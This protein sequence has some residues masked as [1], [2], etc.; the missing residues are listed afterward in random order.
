MSNS[1]FLLWLQFFICSIFIFIAGTRLSLNADIIAEKMGLSKSWIGIL[2]LAPITSGP[3]AFN[4]LSAVLWVKAPDIA[5]GGIL[6]SCVCNLF[7]LALLGLTIG[8]GLS[9]VQIKNNHFLSISFGILMLAVAGVNILLGQHLAFGWISGGSLILFFLYPL[10]MFFIYKAE[11]LIEQKELNEN[12]RD[13]S[14]SHAFKNFALNAFIILIAATWLPKVGNDLAV[15]TSLGQTFVGSIFIAISTSLPEA[16]VSFS[17]FKLSIDMAIGNILGS[18]ITDL[19]FLPIY[20][21]IFLKGPIFAFSHQNQLLNVI[22]AIIMTAI[23]GLMLKFQKPLLVILGNLTMIL[24]YF[25]NLS[26]L[27]YLRQ[28]L[29]GFTIGTAGLMLSRVEGLNVFA[30][31]EH[32][33]SGHILVSPDEAIARLKEGNARYVSMK[34]LSDPGVGP[35]ARKPLTKGQW[36]YATI[37]S[38]SDS[39]VPPELI[40]DEGLGKLFIVRVAGNIINPALLGSIEYASLHSTSRLIMVMGH[41][42]CGAVGAAVHAFEHPETKET[43]GIE[44]IIISL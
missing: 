28:L 13:I 23:F 20:D 36:P 42:S 40:F 38:C 16:V 3:E 32:H 33:G 15:A 30:S 31:E 10:A 5:I 4:G 21:V 2:L 29:K 8:L 43:P 11:R 34:R 1:L 25:L 24:I 27:Y 44:D 37:L 14:L 7:I 12:Y 26:I 39:R 17:A 9:L 18:N 22:S 41:E 6:G 19:F 35:E